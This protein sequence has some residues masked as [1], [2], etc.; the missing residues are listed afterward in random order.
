MT[1]VINLLLLI[2]LQK[3]QLVW[4]MNQTTQCSCK[5]KKLTN[6]GYYHERT[7]SESNICSGIPARSWFRWL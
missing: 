3:W 1:K 6:K 7:C 4:F 2:L 5:L